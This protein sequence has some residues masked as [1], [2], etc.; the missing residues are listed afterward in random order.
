VTPK[1]SGVLVS[2]ALASRVLKHSTGPGEVAWAVWGVGPSRRCLSAALATH[3]GWPS[4]L[5][6][7]IGK[8]QRVHG[9]G[10][11][12]SGPALLI[13]GAERVG[14]VDDAASACINKIGRGDVATQSVQ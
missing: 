14:Q 3:S 11:R 13:H 1:L 5:L 8:G 2:K 4:V 10:F 6:G 7:R 9:Q 12:R